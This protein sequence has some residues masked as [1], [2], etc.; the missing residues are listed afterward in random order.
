MVQLHLFV[1][2]LNISDIPLAYDRP[3]AKVRPFFFILFQH[4]VGIYSIYVLLATI[5]NV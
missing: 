2:L 3:H 5:N 4:K 1:L